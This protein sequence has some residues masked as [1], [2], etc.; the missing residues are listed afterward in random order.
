M[1]PNRIRSALVT[2]GGR[3]TTQ[4]ITRLV[5]AAPENVSAQL[6]SMAARNQVRRVGWDLVRVR[7]W[8]GGQATVTASVWALTEEA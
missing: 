2:L 1:R 3:G 4:D 7:R 8:N 6:A 5:K